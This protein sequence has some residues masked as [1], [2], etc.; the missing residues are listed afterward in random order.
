LPCEGEERKTMD[1]FITGLYVD[2][3]F[4]LIKR[5]VL[6]LMAEKYRETHYTTAHDSALASF[7]RKIIKTGGSRYSCADE[8]GISARRVNRFVALFSRI[9]WAYS[10]R[11]RL[12]AS[13]GARVRATIFSPR[14]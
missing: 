10:R 12:V 4:L 1:G 14:C 8:L 6:E 9:F 2:A 3:G 13:L 11:D 7:C 5:R